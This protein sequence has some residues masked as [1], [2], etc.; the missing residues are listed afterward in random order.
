M[1]KTVID[2]QVIVRICAVVGNGFVLVVNDSQIHG[3]NMDKW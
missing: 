3:W 2:P 1:A